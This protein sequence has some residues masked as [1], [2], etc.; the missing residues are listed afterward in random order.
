VQRL[1]DA[2]QK[3]GLLLFHQ[4]PGHKRA[5]LIDL[6]DSGKEIFFKL[7]EKQS[8]QANADSSSIPQ[9]DLETTLSVLKQIS[10]TIDR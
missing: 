10:D 6:T 7:D 4:N 2:M 3:D 5:K 8:I 9:D 1:V